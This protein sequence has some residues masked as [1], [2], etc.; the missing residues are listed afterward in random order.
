MSNGESV[1]L[2][3][4]TKKYDKHENMRDEVKHRQRQKERH[5]QAFQW[6]DSKAEISS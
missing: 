1:H 6:W 3:L 2:S 5:T 4:K